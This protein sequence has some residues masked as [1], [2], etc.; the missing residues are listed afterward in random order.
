M[1]VNLANYGNNKPEHFG[2]LGDIG[3]AYPSNH[4]VTI[5][6][7]SQALTDKE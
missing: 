7:V 4:T 6:I 5:P 3:P 1:L 2:I